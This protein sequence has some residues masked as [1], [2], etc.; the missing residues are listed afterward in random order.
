VSGAAELPEPEH[1]RYRDDLAAYAL[2]ALAG[3]E[4]AELRA[5]LERCEECR[6]QLRW[7]QPAVDLL[8]RSVAQLRPPRRLRRRLMSTVRSEAR[9]TE[10][11]RVRGRRRRD[12]RALALRPATAAAAGV[13]LAAGLGAGYLLHQPSHGS[14]VVPAT[15]A[16]T[17]PAASGELERTGGTGILRV[18]GM[19]RLA[20]G[21]VYE[22]WVRRG[23][24]VQPSSL[25]SVRDNRSGEA[26][27]PGPLQGA[28]A[29]LV[30]REPRGGSTQPTSPPVLSVDLH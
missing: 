13:F 26:A 10:R 19:P 21:Q 17:A 24:A 25:F 15:A 1:A 2:G 14:S 22:V 8:P 18:Q 30:T 12:W 7:L 5:H 27:V 3:D 6:E 11:E 29:V 16:G 9:A 23:G 28:D 4:E 20:G